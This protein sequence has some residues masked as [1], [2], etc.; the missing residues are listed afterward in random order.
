VTEH[1]SSTWLVDGAHVGAR[2]ALGRLDLDGQK[3]IAFF[4]SERPELDR[5][6]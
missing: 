5:R 4:N 1:E 2:E 6:A 3:Q